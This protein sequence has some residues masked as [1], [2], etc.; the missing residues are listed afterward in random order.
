ML[1]LLTVDLHTMCA[2]VQLFKTFRLTP[3]RCQPDVTLR[4]QASGARFQNHAPDFIFC[5][6]ASD[7]QYESGY[8]VIRLHS[9]ICQIDLSTEAQYGSPVYLWVTTTNR[10]SPR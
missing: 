7:V 6:H 5:D 10:N 3:A 8:V 2:M 9:E 1:M 4:N